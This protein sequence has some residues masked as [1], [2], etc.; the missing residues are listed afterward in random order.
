VR[1]LWK[2]GGGLN[3]CQGLEFRGVVTFCWAGRSLTG[4]KSAR[5]IINHTK[6]YRGASA[7]GKDRMERRKLFWCSIGRRCGVSV[8]KGEKITW[9]G[10]QKIEGKSKVKKESIIKNYPR[11]GFPWWKKMFPGRVSG[12][13]GGLRKKNPKGSDSNGIYKKKEIKL[14][15]AKQKL[16]GRKDV[17]ERH[18]I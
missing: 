13:K 17:S 7:Q 18:P 8:E 11:F 14:E 3:K 6:R 5:K 9:G 4:N 10:V 2:K 1:K 12:G 16:G 15:R